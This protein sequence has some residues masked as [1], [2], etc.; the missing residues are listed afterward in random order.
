[1]FFVGYAS[2]VVCCGVVVV[3]CCVLVVVC[4]DLV[5]A[6]F[7]GCGLLCACC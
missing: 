3:D 5:V 7:F 1:M 6:C 2:L 4:V